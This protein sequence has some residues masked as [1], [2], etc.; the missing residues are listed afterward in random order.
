MRVVLTVQGG[1]VQNAVTDIPDLEVLVVDYDVEGQDP[2][3]LTPIP[4]DTPASTW[5]ELASVYRLPIAFDP[6]DVEMVFGY[7]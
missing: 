3:H 7:E 2:N 4:Q 1:V 6:A 5:T